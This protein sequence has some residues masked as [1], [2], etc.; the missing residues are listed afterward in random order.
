MCVDVHTRF[1][2]AHRVPRL[3]LVANGQEDTRKLSNVWLYSL[4]DE[5]EESFI[6][7][8]HVIHQDALICLHTYSERNAQLGVM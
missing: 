8:G 7:F 1:S 2:T 3:Q 5:G 6:L 4:Y